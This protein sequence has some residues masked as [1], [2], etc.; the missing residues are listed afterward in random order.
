MTK[1]AACPKPATTQMQ[2]NQQ[3]K[4]YELQVEFYINNET[5]MFLVCASGKHKLY[6]KIFL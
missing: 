3:E 4:A 1:R 2:V 5:K 6:I